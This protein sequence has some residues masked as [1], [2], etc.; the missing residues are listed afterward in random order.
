M[1]QFKMIGGTILALLMAGCSDDMIENQ[2]VPPVSG[3]EI[4]FG[5]HSDNFNVPESRTIYEIPG[6]ETV[7]NYTKLNIAWVPDKDSVRVYCP[8]SPKGF[9]WS[10]Y[11]VKGTKT[12]P[13]LAKK[14]YTG[15]RWG[16]VSKDHHFYAFYPTERIVSGLKNDSIIT[17]NIPTA[18]EG[19]AYVRPAETEQNIGNIMLPAHWGLI[20]PNM[21]FAMMGGKGTWAKGT[22]KNVTLDFKPLVSV[23]DV[24]INGPQDGSVNVYYVSVR[25]KEQPI[26]GNFTYNV[27]T[28]DFYGMEDEVSGDNNIA[29]INCT[30]M[31]D[32]GIPA[33]V[34]LKAGE[35]LTLKFFLL[36]RDIK[37]SD[38]SVSVTLDAGRTLTQNLIPE[39][40]QKPDVNLVQGMITRVVTPKVIYPE[41]SNWMSAIGKNVLFT[42]LSLPGSKHSYTGDLYTRDNTQIDTETEYMSFFQSLY[43]SDKKQDDPNAET[44]FDKGIRAFDVKLIYEKGGREGNQMYVYCGS[45]KLTNPNYLGGMKIEDVLTNL[46]NKIQETK[47][48]L[49]DEEV[50][51]PSECAVVCLNYVSDQGYT[52]DEWCSMLVQKVEAWN[53]SKN[54]LVLL[55]PQTTMHDMRGKMAVIIN[56]PSGMTPVSSGVINY[57]STFGSGMNNTTIQNMKLNNL[58]DVHMQNL[59][60][61]NNPDITSTGGTWGV[62]PTVGLVPCY[63]TKSD[64]TL[65][66]DLLAVKKKLVEDLFSEAKRQETD[67]LYINDFAGFCVVKEHK[68]VGFQ[69]AKFRTRGSISWDPIFLFNENSYDEYYDFTKLPSATYEQFDEPNASRGETWLRKGE[70]QSYWGQGGNTAEFAQLFNP[71]ALN[72]I[73]DMVNTGHVPLGLVFM[74]F[75]GVETVTAGNDNQV[76]QVYGNRLPALIMAN[77]FMFPLETVK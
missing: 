15:V 49:P 51:M 9:E 18:Q 61:V 48:K 2:G 22:D 66:K 46:N 1:K 38:L 34:E 17:A 68:S 75:A 56:V 30:Y 42:G 8:E 14:G 32:N 64:F 39:G 13:Y 50:E 57:I 45:E 3:E 27:G 40:S 62:Y 10:D 24:V 12:E 11:A 60:Q 16:D 43:V 23:V 5:V 6:G 33:P 7:T 74:N 41:T 77:N 52:A 25:S 70:D 4:A 29:T 54:V 63:A 31:D 71:I 28:G 69:L 59:Y 35:V 76:Y 37:A 53:N 65:G 67:C 72:A 20:R 26:V 19:G 36:P 58:F 47:T 73:Y 21:T 44:Q 55:T